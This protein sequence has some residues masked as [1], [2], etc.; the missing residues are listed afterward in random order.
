MK[1]LANIYNIKEKE[2]KMSE[3][4]EAE[5]NWD[6]FETT[7]GKRWLK[8]L[9]LRIKNREHECSLIVCNDIGCPFTYDCGEGCYKAFVN[10][11]VQCPCAKLKSPFDLAIILS[12]Y[13]DMIKNEKI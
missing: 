5:I 1:T 2:N 10:L 13:Y 9:N 7:K 12:D 8:Q 3:P 6:W 11:T 4:V